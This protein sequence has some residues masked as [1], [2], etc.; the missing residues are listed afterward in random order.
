MLERNAER[1]LLPFCREMNVGLFPYFVLANGLLAG[2]YKQGVE[3]PKDSRAVEFER[4]RRYLQ[5]YATPENY[6]I[7]DKLIAFARER[8]RRQSPPL[9]AP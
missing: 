3:P 9:A 6:G 2:R 7:I 1:E 4:T 8:V 5:R